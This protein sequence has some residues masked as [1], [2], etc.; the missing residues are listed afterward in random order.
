MHNNI[1]VRQQHQSGNEWNIV[2]I[3][4]ILSSRGV[5]STLL[6][7][8]TN[9]ITSG[10]LQFCGPM[11]QMEKAFGTVQGKQHVILPVCS[12]CLGPVPVTQHN[13][14]F[15]RFVLWYGMGLNP[16]H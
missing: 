7:W 9:P 10:S 15:A 8:T 11:Y 2:R 3:V 13:A 14:E 16:F 1:H 5:L 4:R 12:L 6:D